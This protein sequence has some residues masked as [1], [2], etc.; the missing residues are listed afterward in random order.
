[1]GADAA[2][3]PRE[4]SAAQLLL[5]RDWDARV[6]SI[7][8]RIL[9]ANR[10][11][12]ARQ[13]PQTGL[14]IYTAD[15]YDVPYRPVAVRL[16]GLDRGPAIVAVA[17]SSTAARAG[18]RPGDVL[19][20]IDGVALP[21]NPATGPA[22]FAGVQAIQ[23]RLE[24]ALASPPARL[25]VARG[26]V[27]VPIYLGIDAGCP[28]FVQ[29]VP[30]KKRDAEADGR[31]VTISSAVAEYAQDDD[32]LATPIAHELAHNI[33]GHRTAL[34]R[35]GISKGIFAGFGANG[36]R[37]RETEDEADLT[38]VELM[39]AAGYDPS[40]AIRFWNRFG[41]ASSQLIGDGTHHG[42]RVRVAA[43]ASKVNAIRGR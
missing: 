7:A 25:I 19:L 2:P 30:S 9:T 6:S 40:A 20:S 5:L 21:S 35:D 16:F 26:D 13:V 15:Q 14:V 10:A 8:W 31:T 11:R 42:W 29:L 39:A 34:T 23:D 17:P 1:V 41:P 32:E 3:V 18:L 43:I 38:G 22:T 24:S 27:R 36:R 4:D 33:L 28:S 37:L 12:C